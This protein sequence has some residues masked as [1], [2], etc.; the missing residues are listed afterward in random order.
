ML[1]VSSQLKFKGSL[2]GFFTSLRFVQNNMIGLIFRRHFPQSG[3][4]SQGDWLVER[5]DGR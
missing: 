2:K 5:A 1:F 4:S 3:L